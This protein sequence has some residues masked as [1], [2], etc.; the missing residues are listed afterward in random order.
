MLTVQCQS[1]AYSLL[2]YLR[3]VLLAHDARRLDLFLDGLD[4]IRRNRMRFIFITLFLCQDRQ[5]S[6]L[7]LSPLLALPASAP[8]AS[9]LSHSIL[10][11]R[12]RTCI[13]YRSKDY[14]YN[15]DRR[16]TNG[17]ALLWSC[18]QFWEGLD[19]SPPIQSLSWSFYFVF[20][21]YQTPAHFVSVQQ[22]AERRDKRSIESALWLTRH[23][24]TSN[25]VRICQEKPSRIISS[26][27]KR[28]FVSFFVRP[29][30]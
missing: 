1:N 20:P 3:W 8:R 10:S 5:T 2:L 25:I 16:S 6:G 14:L 24:S 15:G 19:R 28:R 21:K 26:H 9:R 29:K 23:R 18:V 30:K 7:P 17:L 11:A 13:G 4:C 27:H 22:E 12:Y